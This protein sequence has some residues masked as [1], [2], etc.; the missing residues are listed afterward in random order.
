MRRHQQGQVQAVVELLLGLGCPQTP[1]TACPR[2]CL[3][4]CPW[5]PAE[6]RTQKTLSP[7]LLNEQK[8]ETLELSLPNHLTRVENEGSV[9]R[10]VPRI[11]FTH[12][13]FV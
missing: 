3:S 5:H 6:S 1:Q 10:E 4:V 2:G 8:G 11:L 12:Q 9:K 13:L 7:C